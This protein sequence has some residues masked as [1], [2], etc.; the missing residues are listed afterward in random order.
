MLWVAVLQV[1]HQA[2]ASDRLFGAAAVPACNILRQLLVQLH[3]TAT[4]ASILS[5]SAHGQSCLELVLEQMAVSQVLHDCGN[6]G[7]GAGRDV[8]GG[9]AGA[10]VGWQALTELWTAYA[11]LVR[12][13]HRCMRN[14]LDRLEMLPGVFASNE[15]VRLA[16]SLH[17][18][19]EIGLW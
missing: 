8:D 3:A 13:L 18:L 4:V 14:V 12:S 17:S 10:D 15:L 11:G 9:E 2:L 5:M 6:V 19:A 7:G 16:L 1:L